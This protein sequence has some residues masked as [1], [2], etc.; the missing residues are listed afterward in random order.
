MEFFKIIIGLFLY[1]IGLVLL[2]RIMV[3]VDFEH[4][5]AMFTTFLTFIGGLLK[6]FE[7]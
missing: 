7:K 3:H 2:Y 6:F 5:T 4:Q 1:F